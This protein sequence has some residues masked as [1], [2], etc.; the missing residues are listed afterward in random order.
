MQNERGRAVAFLKS[1]PHV[2]ELLT[3]QGVPACSVIQ[4]LL[5]L[6]VLLCSSKRPQFQSVASRV[7]EGRKLEKYPLAHCF[8]TSVSRQTSVK[9]LSNFTLLV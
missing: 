7:E 3:L 5:V 8:S 4:S 2:L 1:F 6:L 9:K